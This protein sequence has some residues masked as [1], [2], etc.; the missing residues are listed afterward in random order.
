MLFV[1]NNLRDSSCI[2]ATKI[3]MGIS[4]Y[5]TKNSTSKVRP[6]V[7]RHGWAVV[8]GSSGPIFV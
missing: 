8:P 7:T 6:R 2:Y 3:E 5:K 1:L 4:S